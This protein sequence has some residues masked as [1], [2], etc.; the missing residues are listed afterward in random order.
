MLHFNFLWIFSRI[1]L[2][3]F[4]SSNFF[5]SINAISKNTT[6]IS[7]GI[8]PKSRLMSEIKKLISDNKKYTKNEPI[9]DIAHE[10]PMRR[11]I[12]KINIYP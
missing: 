8:A 4:S 10:K 9:I 6:K 5:I 11:F 12:S 3:Y 7:P 1:W 2:W